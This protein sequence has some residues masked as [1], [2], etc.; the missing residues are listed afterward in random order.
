MRPRNMA[1]KRLDPNISVRI[2][3]DDLEDLH[4]IADAFRLPLKRFL[5]DLTLDVLRLAEA[6]EEAKLKSTF[7]PDLHNRL[8]LR[9]L[10]RKILGRGKR[11][12]PLD[13]T[14]PTRIPFSGEERPVL[15]G[16]SG[17]LGWAEGYVVW[18]AVLAGLNLAAVDS[19]ITAIPDVIRNI[20]AIRLFDKTQTPAALDRLNRFAGGNRL[21]GRGEAEPEP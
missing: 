15:K 2:P 1:A 8:N 17:I 6:E 18:Q 16:A 9:A 20:W 13:Q 3:K 7:I 12:L 21:L 5:A 14:L 19:E 11:T 10:A 4:V